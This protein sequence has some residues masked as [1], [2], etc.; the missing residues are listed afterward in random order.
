MKN[1]DENKATIPQLLPKSVTGGK[2][3]AITIGTI[4]EGTIA[5]K[6]EGLRIPKYSIGCKPKPIGYT[7]VRFTGV[8]K[9]HREVV[10]ETWN[11]RTHSASKKKG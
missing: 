9:S 7:L 1:K 2:Q 8:T 6:G 4:H 3:S 10:H 5:T 11:K